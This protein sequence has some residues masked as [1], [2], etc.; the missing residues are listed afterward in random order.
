M[1]IIQLTISIS[2]GDDISIEY[3]YFSNYLAIKYVIY[4][5]LEIVWFSLYFFNINLPKKW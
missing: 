4:T 1:L 3:E 2:Q 5:E